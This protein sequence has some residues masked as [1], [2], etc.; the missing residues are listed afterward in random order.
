[1]S[2]SDV[3]REVCEV[4]AIPMGLTELDMKNCNLFPYTYLQRAGSG[5]RSLCLPS[6]KE[7]FEWN[8]KQVASL[9]KSGS[10]IYLLAQDELPGYNILVSQCNGLVRVY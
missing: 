7:T 4:F 6:V 10:F 3:R 5:S 2:D 9:A 1:M 8:G